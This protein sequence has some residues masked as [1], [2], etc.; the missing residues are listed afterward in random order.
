MKKKR[1]K[2]IRLQRDKDG[3]FIFSDDFLVYGNGDNIC[4]AWGDYILSVK[5][6]IE[7]LE[8]EFETNPFVEDELRALKKFYEKWSD[9]E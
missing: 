8:H 6:F 9:S 2:S 5:E 1:S 4:E 7:I 3:T